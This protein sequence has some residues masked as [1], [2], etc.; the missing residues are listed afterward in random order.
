M[1][2]NQSKQEDISATSMAQMISLMQDLTLKM[3]QIVDNKLTTNSHEINDVPSSH[4][5]IGCNDQVQY[6]DKSQHSTV[7][8]GNNYTHSVTFSQMKLDHFA[9]KDEIEFDKILE[10]WEQK[11][12]NCGREKSFVKQAVFNYCSSDLRRELIAKE[13]MT[14]DYEDFKNHLA[15]LLFTAQEA[16]FFTLQEIMKASPH[17]CNTIEEALSIV[18]K[19]KATYELLAKRWQWPEILPDTVYKRAIYCRLPQ[20]VCEGAR[21]VIMH[22]TDDPLSAVIKEIQKWANSSHPVEIKAVDVKFHNPLLED[23]IVDQEKKLYPCRW[24]KSTSHYSSRCEKAPKC[25]K[26]NR[27]GH[28]GDRCYQ[29]RKETKYCNE[30]IYI[31][32]N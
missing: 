27:L 7:L 31:V 20:G 26:C 1:S 11:A 25:D 28:T 19:M 15:K 2:S 5:T 8:S 32:T 17:K 12:M 4:G 22:W 29:F 9:P 23:Y 24:C 14:L 13:L 30:L 10:D 16:I 6:V 21:Y 3:T 18:K